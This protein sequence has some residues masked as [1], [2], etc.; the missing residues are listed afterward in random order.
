ML[1]ENN[2]KFNVL[3]LCTGNSA[4]SIMAEALFNSEAGAGFKAYSAGSNPTGRVNPLAVEQITPLGMDFEPRS[5][6]W[7][8][9]AGQDVPHLDFV[10]TVCDNAAQETCPYFPG[11]PRH[12]HWGLPDPAAVTG[13][14]E[15]K[16]RAFAGCFKI[17]QTRIRRLASQ[18]TT[19]MECEDIRNLM[20]ALGEN[21]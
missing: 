14:D 16:R 21:T 18:V 4:R 9:F 2:G 20:Q 6:N 15:D 5:K 19:E 1:L 11:G 8:E 10:I 3:I 17:L 13:T 12:I 7:D